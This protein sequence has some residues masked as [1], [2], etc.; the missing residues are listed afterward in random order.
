M[1]WAHWIQCM[2]SGEFCLHKFRFILISGLDNPPSI[3]FHHGSKQPHQLRST[4]ADFC[5]KLVNFL[6]YNI[7]SS[8]SENGCERSDRACMCT[9]AC[10]FRWLSSVRINRSLADK[11]SSAWISTARNC[12][13]ANFLFDYPYFKYLACYEY[14]GCQLW[15]MRRMIPYTVQNLDTSI[16]GLLLLQ[17]CKSD[18]V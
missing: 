15:L 9:Y 6:E 8:Y 5:P 7:T 4:K 1:A 18:L 16:I 3:I 13:H 12:D 2:S 10:Y 14:V 11:I 17:I